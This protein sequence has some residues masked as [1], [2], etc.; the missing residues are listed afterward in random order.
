MSNYRYPSWYN[1]FT[2]SNYGGGMTRYSSQYANVGQ[3]YMPTNSEW[4]PLPSANR[5][6]RSVQHASVS[7]TDN[8]RTLSEIK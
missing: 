1:T 3:S 6:R 2:G 8:D 4:L 7:H 5:R